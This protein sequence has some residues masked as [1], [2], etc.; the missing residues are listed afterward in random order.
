M[1]R[2]D[3]IQQVNGYP[4]LDAETISEPEPG[5]EDENDDGEG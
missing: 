1:G 5:D 4:L 3:E 2:D